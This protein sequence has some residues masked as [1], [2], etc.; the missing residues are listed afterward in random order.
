M[1]WNKRKV[2]CAVKLSVSGAIAQ[3]AGKRGCAKRD[4][5]S[6]S[7]L[8][9]DTEFLPPMAVWGMG[10]AMQLAV[11]WSWAFSQG[12]WKALERLR[13]T[14][15]PMELNGERHDR[16]LSCSAYPAEDHLA[17]FTVAAHT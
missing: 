1:L 7:S 17:Y 9:A 15:F 6:L 16:V 2:E 4:Q 13:E 12:A 14:G 10:T 8:T 5:A 11:G 3:S